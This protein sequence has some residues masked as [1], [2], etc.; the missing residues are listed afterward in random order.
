MIEARDDKMKKTQWLRTFRNVSA[1][2]LLILAGGDGRCLGAGVVSWA[3]DCG[4]RLDPK[5][6]GKSQAWFNGDL[7]GR[8]TLPGSTDQ[9]GYGTPNHRSPNLDHLSRLVEYTGPAWYQREVKIPAQWENKR[10]VLFL[11]RCHWTTQVWV[12]NRLV[13]T[14]DSLCVPHEYDLGVLAPG[15]HCLTVSVDNTP[16]YFLGPLDRKS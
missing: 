9:A 11:E 1:I 6:E 16:K 15:K 10:V 7:P 4:F 2:S 3:G 13:G 14:L 12:D 5:K 8:I